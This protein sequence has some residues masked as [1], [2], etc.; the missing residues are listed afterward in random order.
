MYC[1]NY[2]L[3]QTMKRHAFCGEKGGRI[4]A[5]P[6]TACS[7]K[8]LGVCQQDLEQMSIKHQD[9]LKHL[10]AFVIKKSIEDNRP[11]RDIALERFGP[12]VGE[13]VLTRSGH[14]TPE[15]SNV[16]SRLNMEAS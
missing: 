3:K 13:L 6:Q 10:Q 16:N 8:K 9:L 7:T 2:A 15:T 11:P 4:V 14:S 12:I 1:T 5:C